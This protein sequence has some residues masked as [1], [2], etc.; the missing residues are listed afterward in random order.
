[1][2][3]IYDWSNQVEN[4]VVKKSDA[5]NAHLPGFTFTW[6]P[7]GDSIH[8]NRFAMPPPPSPAELIICHLQ[9]SCTGRERVWQNIKKQFASNS[10]AK[11]D[12]GESSCQANPHPHTH[13]QDSLKPAETKLNYLFQS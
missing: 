10:L 5:K 3:E 4:V 9:I 1:M 7:S 12:W 8:L 13:A 2:T 6:S 11:D